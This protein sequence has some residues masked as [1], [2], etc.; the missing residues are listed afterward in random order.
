MEIKVEK[1]SGDPLKDILDTILNLDEKNF[2]SATETTVLWDQ[3][4]SFYYD[5]KKIELPISIIFNYLDKS[6]L[7]YEEDSIQHRRIEEI[8]KSRN[9][10]RC[11]ST[12]CEDSEGIED[13]EYL[14]VKKAFEIL[15]NEELFE[16]FKNFEENKELFKLPNALAKRSQN[17]QNYLRVM[18]SIFGNIDKQGQLVNTNRILDDFYIPDIE[19]YKQKFKELYKTY[20]SQLKEE[21]KKL[22]CRFDA[23]KVDDVVSIFDEDSEWQLNEKIKTEI[24]NGMPEEMSAE[25]K[26]IFIY[27]KMCKLFTYDEGYVYREQEQGNKINYTSQF[28]KKHLEALTIESRITCFDFSRIY[29]KIIDGLDEQMTAVILTQGINKGH[30]YIGFATENCQATLEAIN[31][32]NKDGFEANDLARAKNNMKLDGIKF[33]SG[34]KDVLVNAT[35]KG[36]ASALNIQEQATV[37]YVK[38]LIEVDSVEKEDKTEIES[39]ELLQNLIAKMQKLKISGNEFV[40]FFNDA[41]R[42]FG[43]LKD[44]LERSFVGEVTNEESSKTYK[45]KIWLREKQADETGKH[46]MYLID[47]ETLEISDVT[48]LQMI[49]KLKNGELVYENK[50]HQMNEFE[51]EGK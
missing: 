10:E 17:I 14:M 35:R 39:I 47:T 48:E 34:K 15:K 41:F 46:P 32:T 23:R 2:K 43:I 38:E 5:D 4:L 30:F 29:K 12:L 13:V 25:E 42:R 19:N 27:T 26:A 7:N 3:G 45:R 49:E 6:I 33:V 11:Y 40:M 16:K 18:I 50:E 36:H 8:I 51:L 24:L 31:I 28:S 1:K 37:D 20:E 21:T 22:K 9:E 44:S